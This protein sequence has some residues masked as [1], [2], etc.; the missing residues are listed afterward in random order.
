MSKDVLRVGLVLSA[1]FC[2]FV[3][4][5]ISATASSAITRSHLNLFVFE[6]LISG[7]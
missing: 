3:F 7:R 6:A 4:V 1:L 2:C 5:M